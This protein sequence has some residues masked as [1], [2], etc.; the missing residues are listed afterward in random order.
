M[1]RRIGLDDKGFF[2][3]LLD[4]KKKKIIVEHYKNVKKKNLI[5]SGEINEMFEGTNA[6]DLCHEI[7]ERGLIS[8]LDHAAYLGRELQKSEI[9]LKKN[10]E[11]IQDED[12]KR[13]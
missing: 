11:Y 1:V 8:R 12:L 10:I 13:N 3:I 9:A 2:V 7:I 4:R 6:E 5:V